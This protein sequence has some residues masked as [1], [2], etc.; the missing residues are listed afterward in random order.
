[1]KKIFVVLVALATFATYAFA[2][3]GK[4]Q[5][6]QDGEMGQGDTQQERITNPDQVNLSVRQLSEQQKEIIYS[7]YEEEKLARDVYKTFGDMYPEEN[8]FANIQLSEQN[9][10]DAVRNLCV[11]YGIDIPTEDQA[12]GVFNIIAMKDLFDQFIGS[13]S[14]SLLDALEVGI[15]IE[16]MDI[17]DLGD[18]LK[19][20]PKDVVMVFNNLISGSV[21]HW[22]AFDNAI[23]RETSQ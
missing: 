9:H 10:M 16:D 12:V 2:E 14:E 7:I 22:N 20:M 4:N 15:E 13:G 23:T 18:A 19:G 11:K 3:G 8:T 17:D 6:R 1:M 21:N 5:K